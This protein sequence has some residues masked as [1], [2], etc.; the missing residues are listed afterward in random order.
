MKYDQRRAK[1]NG[2]CRVCQ[3][4]IFR[5]ETCVYNGAFSHIDCV[6]ALMDEYPRRLNPHYRAVWGAV[7]RSRLRKHL[8]SVLAR[9]GCSQPEDLFETGRR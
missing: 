9:S 1:Y 4:T 7:E 8:A 3:F 6:A 5:G 2:Y